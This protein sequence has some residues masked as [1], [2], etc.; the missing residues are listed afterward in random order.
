MYSGSD[1]S[2]ETYRNKKLRPYKWPQQVYYILMFYLGDNGELRL[3]LNGGVKDRGYINQQ[4]HWRYRC[5]Y[6]RQM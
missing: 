1:L 5:N 6:L 4:L 2:G 3:T